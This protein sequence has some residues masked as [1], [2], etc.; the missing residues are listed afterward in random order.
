MLTHDS[1]RPLSPGQP[2]VRPVVANAHLATAKRFCLCALGAVLA[3]SAVAAIIAL[4]T[5]IYF[6]R[7]HLGTG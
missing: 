7:F 4:K 5:S 3:G 6:V 2:S 1:E